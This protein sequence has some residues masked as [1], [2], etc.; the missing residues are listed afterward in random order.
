MGPYS[1]DFRRKVVQAY[2]SRRGSHRQ[3]AQMFGVSLSF[4]QEL[5]QRYRRTGSVEPKAHGGGNPGKLVNHLAVV[6][7]LHQHQPDATLAERCE[8]VA[9]AVQVRVSRR[10][11]SR[12]LQR[13]QLT[14]KK[15]PSTPLSK[16]R[17]QGPRRG[18]PT[19]RVWRG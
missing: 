7:Q 10:T 1:L 4:V 17:R 8:R 2:E 12:A 19:G 15:R 11:M 13:L 5:W 16:T 18:A 9:A 3:L 6:E 14:R